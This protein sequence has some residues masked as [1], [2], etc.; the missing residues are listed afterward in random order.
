VEWQPL[1]AG[2]AVVAGS[3]ATFFAA[4]ALVEVGQ[5]ATG[6]ER[7]ALKAEEQGLVPPRRSELRSRKWTD[8][9]AGLY[10]LESSYDAYQ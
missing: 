4:R 1:A 8:V 7:A 6:L 2:V 3:A 9:S 10:K 5:M